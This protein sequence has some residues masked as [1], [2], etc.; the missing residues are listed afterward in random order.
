MS[1]NIFFKTIAM[2]L[3][4]TLFLAT[5]LFVL[6]VSATGDELLPEESLVPETS[7]SIID[8]EVSNNVV[9]DD[10]D[11]E[12]NLMEEKKYPHL[13]GGCAE[14]ENQGVV[15]DIFENA[16]GKLV[17][18]KIIF[19]NEISKY[20]NTLFED[21]FKHDNILFEPS[22][23]DAICLPE[24][25]YRV[26]VWGRVWFSYSYGIEDNTVWEFTQTGLTFKGG[27]SFISY[28]DEL[29][30][31][32]IEALESGVENYLTY[33]DQAAY[34]CGMTRVWKYQEEIG[35]IYRY[36]PRF[37]YLSE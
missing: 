16:T 31:E 20:I 28:V 37:P 8:E 15:I 29:I 9:T 21:S 10:E 3:A 13:G 18:Q 1:K 36:T 7:D 12:D 2:V 33:E 14:E 35:S 5:G 23:D 26:E 27:E 30:K 11:I 6:I 17:G 34:V 22:T 19:S 32:D 25:K 24:A 4:A